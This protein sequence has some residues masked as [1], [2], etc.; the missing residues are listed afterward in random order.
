MLD[1][2]LNSR[3]KEL[4]HSVKN[5][6]EELNVVLAQEEHRERL[7]TDL[8]AKCDRVTEDTEKN[9]IVRDLRSNAMK[10]ATRLKEAQVECGRLKM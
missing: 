8:K 6:K 4:I 1:N 3:T 2:H 9:P 10:L 7:I 5:A